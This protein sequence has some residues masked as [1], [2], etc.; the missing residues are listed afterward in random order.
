MWEWAM[1]KDAFYKQTLNKKET[2][3]AST[4]YPLVVQIRYEFI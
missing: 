3:S 2:E 1:W 4:K